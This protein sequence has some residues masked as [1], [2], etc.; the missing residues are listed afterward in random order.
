MRMC[1]RCS[2]LTT[3]LYFDKVNLA[4]HIKTPVLAR[5]GF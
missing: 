2:E 4:S 1:E 5:N 3:A